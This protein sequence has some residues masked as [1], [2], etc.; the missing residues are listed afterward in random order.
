MGTSRPESTRQSTIH[1]SSPVAGRKQRGS[2]WRASVCIIRAIMIYLCIIGA[3]S[4]FIHSPI[5]TFQQFG[6]ARVDS[7][8]ASRG[9]AGKRHQRGQV[10]SSTR[11]QHTNRHGPSFRQ[12]PFLPA[13]LHPPPPLALLPVCLCTVRKVRHLWP[14]EL[15]QPKPPRQLTGQR[16][17]LPRRALL[18][19]PAGGARSGT[20]AV[21]SGW[22]KT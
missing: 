15:P 21:P 2:A 12:L 18:A 8:K 13:P 3:V 1:E 17:A 4:R 5:T 19:C 11:Q 20:G 9:I 10:G 22:Q 7:R 16:P 14:Q 6:K